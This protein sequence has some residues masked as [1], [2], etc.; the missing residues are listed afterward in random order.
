MPQDD[1]RDRAKVAEIHRQPHSHLPPDPALRM[2]AL[3]SLAVERGFV[4]RE[5]LDAWVEAYSERIGPK[6]G[7]RVLARAWADPGYHSRL[8][9]S[10]TDAIRDFGFE[11][12]ATGHLRSV[13]NS[14][15]LHNLVVCTL[16]SC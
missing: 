3:E 8:L 5:T 1:K 2:K 11:G 12:N 14:A 10:A 7:A 13:E 6:R 16:C 4:A 15:S 9:E